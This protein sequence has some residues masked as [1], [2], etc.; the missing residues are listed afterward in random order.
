MTME[1]ENTP[2]ISWKARPDRLK[3]SDSEVH[4][5]R[6]N[7]NTD[8]ETQEQVAAC[9]SAE[10]RSRAERFVFPRDRHHWA[11]CHGIL[12]E[13]LGLYLNEHPR[14][15]E[16]VREPGGKPRLRQNPSCGE[17]LIMFNLSHSNDLALVAV[18]L[19]LE[20]GIDVENVRPELATAE[21]AER[22]FSL[23]EQAEFRSLPDELRA[24]AFFH[25]W[26]RKEAF[27]KARGE[28]LATPLD[29]F[30]VSLTP[31]FPAVLRSTDAPRWHM[32]SFYPAPHA[33]AALVT[34]GKR[35][36]RQFWEWQAPTNGKA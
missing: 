23:E 34:E 5:W 12:R 4:V 13:I 11:A 2:R 20:V 29:S 32:F 18:T 3:M 19:A 22:Y 30:S 26:T 16:I 27:V 28:G 35:P 21:I 25:C 33:V 8:S 17:P 24:E 7:L 15:I 14:D 6:A 10:E 1:R 9:L 36:K 31:G